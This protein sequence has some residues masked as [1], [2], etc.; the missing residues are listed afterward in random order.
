MRQLE[1]EL[2]DARH[3]VDRLEWKLENAARDAELQAARV[4]ERAQADHKR[5]LEARDELIALL[6]EKLSRLSE[7]KAMDTEV[8]P[9]SSTKRSGCPPDSGHTKY[10]EPVPSRGRTVRLSLPHPP[11]QCQ[12][13][14]ILV[15]H[16]IPPDLLVVR[17]VGVTATDQ[18]TA[19]RDDHHLRHPQGRLAGLVRVRWSRP[20]ELFIEKRA[21]MI[22]VV[23][24]P[25]SL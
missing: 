8:P 6:K 5:E 14:F 12:Q 19:H 25:I 2:D 9:R 17:N 15:T 21:R 3:E 13:L 20:H 22:S 23:G 18:E 16:L 11:A 7:H 4:K 24:L 10:P 1:L